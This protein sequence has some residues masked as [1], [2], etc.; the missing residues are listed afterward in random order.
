MTLGLTSFGCFEEW[1][2]FKLDKLS[3]SW[4]HLGDNQQTKNVTLRRPHLGHLYF[5]P[6]SAFK[7]DFPPLLAA[8]FSC[9]VVLLHQRTASLKHCCQ[10]TLAFCC[11]SGLSALK[12]LAALQLSLSLTDCCFCR[13]R[14]M[15][16]E[17]NAMHDCDELKQM[18]AA[19][20]EKATCELEMR[21]ES[22]STFELNARS[23]KRQTGHGREADE[24]SR[25]ARDGRP[26]SFRSLSIR[27]RASP[28]IPT[29]TSPVSDAL[30]RNA[31]RDLCLLFSNQPRSPIAGHQSCV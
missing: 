28:S 31:R 4:R 5:K 13:P 17:C 10:L 30:G 22:V 14:A 21:L 11:C 20:R 23:Q 25:A 29:A 18:H 26:S 6:L 12:V 1:W 3:I 24:L 7:I 27:P 15:S 16:A 2:S 19:M 8:S 9:S